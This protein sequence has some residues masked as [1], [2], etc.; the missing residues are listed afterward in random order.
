MEGE[1]FATAC[2]VMGGFKFRLFPASG[3]LKKDPFQL[4]DVQ[5]A[6]TRKSKESGWNVPLEGACVERTASFD[7]TRFHASKGM[8]WRWYIVMKGWFLL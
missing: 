2:V 8:G 7:C 6:N 5:L 4:M 1:T 3:G